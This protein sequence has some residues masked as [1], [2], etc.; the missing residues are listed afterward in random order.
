MLNDLPKVVSEEEAELGMERQSLES[1]YR[2]KHLSFMN[3]D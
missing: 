2:Q 3:I 1:A